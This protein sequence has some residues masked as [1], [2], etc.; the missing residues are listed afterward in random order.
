MITERKTADHTAPANPS[1]LPSELLLQGT[2]LR[3][4]DILLHRPKMPNLTQQLISKKTGSPYTH[5]SICLG[6]NRQAEFVWP[7]FEVNSI[8][9]LDQATACIAVLR[10]QMVFGAERVRKLREFAAAV[11]GVGY[12]FQGALALPKTST[13]FFD[14][15]LEVISREFGQYRCIE[16]F[17]QRSYFCSSFV[18]A[19]YSVVEIIDKSAQV[20]YPPD[21][22]SPGHLYAD[23]TFGWLLGYLLPPGGWVTADDPVQHLAQWRDL[24]DCH[25]WPPT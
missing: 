2:D 7:E 22:F 17:Q 25:W 5:A 15:Q 1:D 20:A 19:C 14:N 4:G 18:V 23:A 9:P 8:S 3:A 11:K 21:A 6:E 10:S 13:R 16:E 24:P 12:N